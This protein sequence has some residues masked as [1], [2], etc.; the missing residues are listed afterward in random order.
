MK[1]C[2]HKYN[3]QLKSGVAGLV[4]AVFEFSQNKIIFVR[5]KN[6]ILMKYVCTV[7]GYVHDEEAEGVKFE[8]LSEDWLCPVCG[9]GKDLFEPEQ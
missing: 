2:F 5:F 6:Q 1:Q 8:Q 7:C 4:P 3:Q 9:V